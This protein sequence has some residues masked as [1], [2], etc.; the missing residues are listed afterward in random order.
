MRSATA[1]L[2]VDAVGRKLHTDIYSGMSIPMGSFFIVGGS[3]FPKPSN[4]CDM[5][6]TSLSCAPLIFVGFV[7]VARAIDVPTAVRAELTA[8]AVIWRPRP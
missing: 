2:C 7:P 8:G 1:L 6:G 3:F 4:I 5:R